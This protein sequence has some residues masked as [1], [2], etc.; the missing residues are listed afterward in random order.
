M[1]SKDLQYI[2]TIAQTKNFSQA[3]KQL[4][5]SQPALSQYVKRLEASLRVQIFFRSHSQVLLTP[6][7]E[8]FVKEGAK[9]LNELNALE[10]QLRNFETESPQILSIGVSQFYGKHILSPLISQLKETIPTYKIKIVE[11]E[12]KFLENLIKNEQLDFGIFPAPIYNKDV[13]FAPIYEEQ[14]LFA[15]NKKNTEASTLAKKAFHG[16]G[17]DLNLYKHFPFIL[18]QEGL[19]LRNR[20]VKICTAYG[21]TPQAVYETENLDTVLSLVEN[22]YGVA[23]LP[24][25]IL[26]KIEKKKSKV[27]FYPIKSRYSK[28]ALGLA[29]KDG[30]YEDI[31]LKNILDCARECMHD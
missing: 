8:V 27:A 6:V 24:S 16:D 4:F 26:K 2:I 9:I 13:C 17:I 21:F 5:V 31:F 25:T 19:K 29:Y 12:S 23:M 11:G 10:H 1:N 14:I 7:G 3:A 20:A 22:N 18:L 30:R 15:F 28:R